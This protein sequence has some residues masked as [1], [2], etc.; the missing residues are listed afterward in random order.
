MTPIEKGVKRAAKFL[1][2]EI[3]GWWNMIDPETLQMSNCNLCAMGQIFGSKNEEKL[4]EIIDE[5]NFT[6]IKER[7]LRNPATGAFDAGVNY[8]YR[9][10]GL[11]SNHEEVFPFGFSGRCEWIKEIATRRAKEQSSERESNATN[12]A[13]D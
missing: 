4:A 10:C 12:P 7:I 9:V 3:P 13:Q 6:K 5:E 2:K 8:L 11:T 1:D